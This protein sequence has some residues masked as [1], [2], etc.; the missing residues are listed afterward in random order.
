MPK[1]GEVMLRSVL[2]IMF[3]QVGEIMNQNFVRWIKL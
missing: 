2:G 3:A 1:L